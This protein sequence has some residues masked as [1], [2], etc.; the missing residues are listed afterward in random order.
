[1][2]RLGNWVSGL[3]Q[4]A[5]KSIAPAKLKSDFAET[6]E[7]TPQEFLEAGDKLID[8]NGFW[9]WQPAEAPELENKNLHPERQFLAASLPV[10]H[11]PAAPDTERAVPLPDGWV[12]VGEVGD[13]APLV[14]VDDEVAVES[15]AEGAEVALERRVYELNITY[16]EYYHCAR[17]W[18]SG[19]DGEGR[20]L[21][22]EK[23]FEEVTAEYKDKTMTFE[24]HPH[25]RRRMASL[26]PCRHSAVIKS[27]WEAAAR[28]GK[29]LPPDAYLFVFLKFVGSVIPC[30]DVDH[31]VDVEL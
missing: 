3:V 31:T 20:P 1:M 26:H 5:S 15:I 7:V 19:V 18:L 12:E 23:I 2:H 30:L 21:T 14:S 28:G 10:L 17:L 16:D 9:R 22:K 6:G 4:S 27:M 8:A 24:T 11:R 13:V 29:P 25:L